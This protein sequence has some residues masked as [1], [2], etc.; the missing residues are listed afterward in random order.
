[1]KGAN[2]DDSWIAPC[3]WMTVSL[4]T[5]NEKLI[6]FLIHFCGSIVKINDK[7]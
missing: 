4:D 1:M 2:I 5:D 6:E 7:Y 3:L